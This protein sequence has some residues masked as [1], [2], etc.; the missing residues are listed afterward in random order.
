MCAVPVSSHDNAQWFAECGDEQLGDQNEFDSGSVAA[1][2]LV[3]RCAQC[4][5]MHTHTHTLSRCAQVGIL[6]AIAAGLALIAFVGAVVIGRRCVFMCRRIRHA[7]MFV[8]CMPSTQCIPIV[9]AV[10]CNS[11]RCT[12]RRTAA[13]D[14]RRLQ[15]DIVSVCE[16]LCFR[17]CCVSA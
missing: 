12:W 14:C 16:C 10:L 3:R 7:F 15:G 11:M 6:G 2:Y 9:V 8:A 13:V 4:V 17:L 5:S 1:I